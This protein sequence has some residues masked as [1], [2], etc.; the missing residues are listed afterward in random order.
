MEVVSNQIWP[1]EHYGLLKMFI[2]QLGI[3][4]TIDQLISKP[5]RKIS[6]GNAVAAIIL[7]GIGFTNRALYLTPEFLEFLPVEALFGKGVQPTDFND[8][9]LGTALDALFDAGVTEVFYRVAHTALDRKNI[10]RT[11]LHLDSTSF[12]FHGVYKDTET[13]QADPEYPTKEVVHITHGYSKDHR[14]DLKQVI[15][16]MICTH[17]TSIPTWIEVLD[18]NS[19]DKN[20]FSKTVEKF[21]NQLKDPDTMPVIV[22]DSALYSAE[23]LAE[24]SDVRWITRV[25][26]TLSLAKRVI[27]TSEKATMTELIHGYITKSVNIEYAGIPQRWLVVFSQAAYEREIQTFRNNLAKKTTEASK[28][29]WHISNQEFACEPDARAAVAKLEKTLKYHTIDYELIA[30]PHYAKKGKPN[31]ATSPTRFGWFIQGRIIE[32]SQ[33][34]EKELSRKGFFIIATNVLKEADLSDGKMLSVYKAQGS[35]VER[36]FRFLKDPMFYAES[37]Y[38]KSSKRIMALLMVMTLALLV[39]S[40]SEQSIR[41]ALQEHKVTVRNQLKKPTNTPTLK[42]VFMLFRWAYYEEHILEDGS[43]IY[44][45]RLKEDQRTILKALGPPFEKC[46]FL[47]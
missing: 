45:P 11:F 29:L 33:R 25:P 22:A 28:A 7:N 18:G 12:S 15:L 1:I 21:R 14:S 35:S 43:F 32:D 20:T 27:E 5:K 23:S 42:W 37:L 26:E 46:Y 9:S 30:K 24:L 41:L 4:E 36:G 38:L 8:D 44:V 17:G 19:C 13:G 47:S 6:V 16:Q 34:I 10:D 31:S 3:T 2:D 40:L 39:Y